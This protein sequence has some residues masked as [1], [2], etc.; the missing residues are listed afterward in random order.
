[1]V[2]S[3]TFI[4]AP[5]YSISPFRTSLVV[6]ADSNKRI[7]I[8]NLP[9]TLVIIL[10]CFLDFSFL[11]SLLFCSKNLFEFVIIYRD[12]KPYAGFNYIPFNYIGIIIFTIGM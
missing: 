7:A 2:L 6:Q 8:I 10:V 9:D 11:F 5:V 1:M 12:D 4:L 3:I